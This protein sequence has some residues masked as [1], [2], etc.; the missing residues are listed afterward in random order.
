MKSLLLRAAA[1]IAALLPTAFKRGLYRLGPVSEAIRSSLSQAAPRGI[2]E[3]EIA[4]GLLAGARFELDL[5]EEKSLWLGTYELD[6][7][8][9]LQRV[10][11][12][13]M[14]VYDLGA[15][16]GYLTVGLARLVGPRGQV[17]AFEAHPDNLSRLRHALKMNGCTDRVTVVPQAVGASPG[18]GMFLLHASDD[19]GKLA[20][21]SGRQA[22]Y[23]RSIEVQ[24]T[25]LDDYVLGGGRTVPDWI[26]LDVEGG[27]GAVLEGAR[28]LLRQG[29]T[30]F[31][32]EI[33]GPEAA[34]AV[35][36]TFSAS[37]YH[38]ADLSGRELPGPDSVG[39]KAYVGA[40]PVKPRERGDDG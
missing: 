36:K 10:I 18:T 14:I 19:M 8:N 2:T 13:G 23:E 1:R 27:E 38:L 9:T 34:A 37:G 15:N 39:W 7:Q 26:K 11:E 16:I 22:T 12:R 25:T 40:V 32:L 31:L 24:V 6:L 4:S 5:Q 17:H 3:V 20:G 30:R 28:R 29:R 21:S 35:W 33:H